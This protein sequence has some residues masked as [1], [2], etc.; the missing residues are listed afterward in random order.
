MVSRFL[1]VVAAF[2]FAALSFAPSAIV[3]P[4]HSIILC[5]AEG[6]SFSRRT[7]LGTSAVIGATTFWKPTHAQAVG[8]VKLNLKNPV[9]SAKPCPP[10]KPI[11]G[12]K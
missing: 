1:I 8:P 6:S 11:P 3:V 12:E 10:E 5:H 4:H 2:P 9:Y 7:F